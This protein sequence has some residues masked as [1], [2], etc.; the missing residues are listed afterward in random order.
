MKYHTYLAVLLSLFFVFSVEAADKPLKVY[1]LAGQSN[2]DGHAQTRTIAA[3]KGDP[4]VADLYNEMVDKDGKP[5][6]VDGVYFVQDERSQQLD[7]T[8]GSAWKGPK[9]GPEYAFG[10]TMHKSLE[11]PIL[12]IKTAWGGRDLIQHFRPPS[13]GDYELETD[14]WGNKT[15]HY[16]REMIK[17]VQDVLAD[18]GKHHPDY[19]K[20]AGYEI[21]GFVWFQ[22]FNDQFGPYPRTDPEDSDSVKDFSEYGRLLACLIRDVRKDL[23]APQ[24]KVVI[25]AIG[26]EGVVATEH[27]GKLPR[28]AATW[29]MLQRAQAAP[30]AM[31]E[32]KGDVA[33]VYTGKYWD[34]KLGQAVDRMKK[35]D[36][37]VW[38]R[39][40][41]K[42]VSRDEKEALREE[43]AA[44]VLKPG[45]R[46][47]LKGSSDGA[48]HY[49]GSAKI[50]S[51]IGKAFAEAMIALGEEKER[52]DKGGE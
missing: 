39:T 16:Y 47:I 51:R 14:K 28:K 43:I 1:I 5:I 20:E 46:E 41:D 19:D 21:A 2:M 27:E 15:G 30:A 10:I 12:L 38:G 37:K 18:P 40:K 22:G 26:I 25:G 9:V 44:E 31:P 48:Y 36:R 11:Q 23:S 6:T 29:V 35:V 42:K 45:D 17:G 7:A 13:A 50:Y 33:V 8:C 52:A 49:L 24:M 32:F 34:H 4:E 3:M